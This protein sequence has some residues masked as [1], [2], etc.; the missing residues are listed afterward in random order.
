MLTTTSKSVLLCFA[1]F[2][3]SA[4]QWSVF[5]EDS[6]NDKIGNMIEDIEQKQKEKEQKEKEKEREKDKKHKDKDRDH[7]DDSDSDGGCAGEITADIIG[8]CF[9]V[10]FS[11]LGQYAGELIYSDYPYADT[12]PFIFSDIRG[13]SDEGGKIGFLKFSYEPSYLFDNIWGM[14][15]RLEG[16]LSVLYAN[17]LFQ[18]NFSGSDRESWFS[19]LSFNGGLAIPI[20]NVMLSLYAGVFTFTIPSTMFPMLTTFSFGGSLQIFFPNNIEF[21]LY[22]LNAVYDPFWF[23]IVSPSISIAISRFSIGAGFDY[24]NYAGTVYMGPAIKL[25]VWI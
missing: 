23:I 8:G 10:F 16:V 24:Y 25:T 15:G 22:N 9:D 12:S 18:Y 19:V 11:I 5:S 3:L 17:C 1:L 7:S 13:D 2:I 21:E 4:L 20:S 14:S 6:G